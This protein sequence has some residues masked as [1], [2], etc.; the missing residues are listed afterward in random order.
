MGR[1]PTLARSSPLLFAL[2][3][4]CDDANERSVTAPGSR[5]QAIQAS[6]SGD[7]VPAAATVAHPAPSAS[8]APKRRGKLCGGKL[9]SP[10]K[11]MPTSAIS[12]AQAP[13]EAELASALPLRGGKWTWVNFWAAWCAPCKEE[14]P[15][16]K[17]WEQKLG[18]GSQKLRV[19]FISLDDDARQLDQ[20]LQSQPSGGLRQTYWLREGKEREEW[21]EAI[22]IEADPQLPAH[23]LVDPT[24]KARCFVSGAVEDEDYAELVALLGA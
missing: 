4:G 7:T 9:D 10:A 8:I 24:G 19:A 13:G 3:G 12:R 14:I 21:L 22:E 15:R 20:F 1:L 6:G 18:Q 16:L 17:S 11:K 23:V 5:A 2:L